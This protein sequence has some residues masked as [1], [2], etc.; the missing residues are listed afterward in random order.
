[1][2]TI[3][4]VSTEKKVVTFPRLTSRQVGLFS[5]CWPYIEREERLQM[6]LKLLLLNITVVLMIVGVP[7]LSYAQQSATTII[8]GSQTPQLIPD[9]LAYRLYFL[10]V[11]SLPPS[12]GQAQLHSAIPSA[13]ATDL[14][15]ATTAIVAFRTA[16][17]SLSNNY[18]QQVQ[19]SSNPDQNFFASQRDALVANTRAA[20]QK[21][22]S[23][24]GMQKF[25]AHVQAE[26]KRMKTSGA[27]T[28]PMN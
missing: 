7:N 25:D 4:P 6:K 3:A 28:M 24:G 19:A 9:T 20:L 18:N 17:D 5:H 11:T 10:A 12:V 13:T 16:Y 21:T 15:A 2:T 22:L 1:M 26:K 23:A 14:Q 8:D 27:M